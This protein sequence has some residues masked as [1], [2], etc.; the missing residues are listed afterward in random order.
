MKVVAEKHSAGKGAE[1][2]A[3]VVTNVHKGSTP[4]GRLRLHT[5]R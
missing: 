5:L 2:A 1:T 4:K 3:L